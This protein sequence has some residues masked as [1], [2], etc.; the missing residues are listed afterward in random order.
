MKV[1][2]KQN[3]GKKVDSTNKSRRMVVI[4]YVHGVSERV[5]RVYKFYGIAIAMKLHNTLRKELVHHKDKR[6]LENIT[7]AIY[8]CPCMNCELSYIGET[9]RKFGN[10]LKNI[11]QKW[12]K[13]AKKLLPE[14]GEKNLSPPHIYLPSQTMW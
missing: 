5:A 2:K 9:G 13:C 8:E 12:K 1:P 10:R 6:D 11:R 7:D 14:P 3:T 4:P